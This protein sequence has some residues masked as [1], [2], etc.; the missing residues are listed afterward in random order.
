M[1]INQLDLQP[2][3]RPKRSGRG[4]AAG[5][6][7]TAGRG[8]KGQNSRSGGGVRVGFEGGQNPLLQRIPKQRGSGTKRFETTEITTTT[9]NRL[10]QKKVDNQK[11]FEAGLIPSLDTRVKIILKDPVASAMSLTVFAISTGALNSL[12]K[13]GGQFEKLQKSV[14]NTKTD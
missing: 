14:N 11:L 7:K 2:K 1:K 5:R 10:G 9:L 8:T 13:A 4:I 6:G 3:K 12:E